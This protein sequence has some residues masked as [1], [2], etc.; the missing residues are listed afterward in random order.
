VFLPDNSL[1]SS[2]IKRSSQ[3]LRP[4]KIARCG[5]FAP[6]VGLAGAVCR[7]GAGRSKAAGWKTV[8]LWAYLAP[9]T[10]WMD[11]TALPRP[12]RGSGPRP[13]ARSETG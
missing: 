8:P 13:M 9:V 1:A 4:I 6:G 12:G 5:G 3:P 2:S 7:G 11:T 10:T